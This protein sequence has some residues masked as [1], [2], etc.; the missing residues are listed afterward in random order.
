MDRLKAA[1]DK[2]NELNA[3]LNKEKVNAE[4]QTDF[5]GPDESTS[6][7]EISHSASQRPRRKIS[8]PL[9]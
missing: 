3:M 1:H 4:T 8:A 7:D 5:V 9:A 2:I 6:D